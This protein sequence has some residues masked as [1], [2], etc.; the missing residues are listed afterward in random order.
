MP[1]TTDF[2]FLFSLHLIDADL[3]PERDTG[4][5]QDPGR[6]GETTLNCRH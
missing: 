4:E 3:S 1:V 6:R 2:S 5:D